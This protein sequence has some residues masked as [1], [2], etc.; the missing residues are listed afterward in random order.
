MNTPHPTPAF[1]E[2]FSSASESLMEFELTPAEAVSDTPRDTCLETE[3]GVSVR[4]VRRD[5]AVWLE[6]RD[7]D[8]NP[9]VEI[10]VASGRTRV[11]ARGS[12]AISA[13]DGDLDL[14]AR[15]A[16]R[17]RGASVDLQA[18]DTEN[19]STLHLGR[20]F[21]SLSSRVIDIGAKTARVAVADMAY[22]GSH[23]RAK[24]DDV[25]VTAERAEQVV[26]RFFQ[27]A[28]SVFRRVE[29]LE[30]TRAGRIRTLVAGSY[31][32]KGETTTVEADDDV[33]V[34]GK[35]IHLG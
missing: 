5:G 30:Q 27:T 1:R 15:G 9:I 28:K 24:L 10:D 16:V 20:S 26:G 7:V 3:S 18:G 25:R 32:L 17:V 12:L 6:I 33:R 29:D 22:A 34:D 2:A 21:A 8:K 14:S 13:P 11:H 19:G 35:A 4:K 31:Y 23:L